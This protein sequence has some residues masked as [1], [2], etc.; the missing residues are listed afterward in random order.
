M[1]HLLT[2]IASSGSEI[3]YT[4]YIGGF[5]GVLVN[6][7]DCQVVGLKI[8]PRRRNTVS[9]YYIALASVHLS[10]ELGT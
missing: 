4:V 1:Y 3:R 2:V 8:D 9:K 6:V 5:V 10:S 7:L